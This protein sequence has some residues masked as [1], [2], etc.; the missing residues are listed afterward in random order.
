M[1]LGAGSP[2]VLAAAE[3]LDKTVFGN[4]VSKL[5]ERTLSESSSSP[6]SSM[7]VIDNQE[8]DLMAGGGF[9]PPTF[10]L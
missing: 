7:Q 3:R 1:G 4:S 9:E 5:L 2:P 8:L 10:G 6:R